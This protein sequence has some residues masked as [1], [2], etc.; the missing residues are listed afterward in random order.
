MK[1]RLRHVTT[2]AIAGVYI[3]SVSVA[4][5]GI[6][7]AAAQAYSGGGTGTSTDPYQIN[8]CAQLAEIATEPAAFYLLTTS[9]DCTSAGN[10]IIVTGNLTGGFDGG[11]H[12]LTIN[13]TTSTAG[14]TLALFNG[15]GYVNGAVIKNLTLAG[16]VQNQGTGADSTASLAS[17]V[18]NT[19]ISN[20][21]STVQV[22][23][24]GDVGGLVGALSI[25][26]LSDSS[27]SA[28]VSGVAVGGV[29]SWSGCDSNVSNVTYSGTITASGAAGGFSAYDTC[30]G[31]GSTMNNV[32]TS[33][34]INA[35]GDNVGGLIGQSVLGVVS[36]SSSSMTV[37]GAS[38]VG[39]LVGYGSSTQIDQSIATGDVHGT[40]NQVGGFIGIYDSMTIADS[41]A[42]GTVSGGNDVAG[43][44]GKMTFANL[45]R[46]YATGQVTASGSGVG[47]GSSETQRTQPSKMRSGIQR[48]PV[49]PPALVVPAKSRPT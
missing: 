21:H 38:S 33:G 26:T 37:Y 16:Q 6:F 10:S 1:Q 29:S 43:F 28:D 49:K 17:R 3:I 48:Q 12:T 36:K 5:L 27:V 31:N 45:R 9:L 35:S 20:I 40:G 14:V 41:Y 44:A 8:S 23:S 47:G 39:G 11:N 42:R 13:L 22:T 15:S 46:S 24:T 18:Y 25:S 32:H 30:E 19:T 7:S 34:T 4:G 2:A